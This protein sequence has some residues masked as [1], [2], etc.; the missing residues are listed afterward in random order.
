MSLPSPFSLDFLDVATP[1]AAAP[2]LTYVEFVS[3]ALILVGAPMLVFEISG[4]WRRGRLDWRR[5]TGMATS[6]FCL[7]PA[8]IAEACLAAPV[9]GIFFMVA[10]LAPSSIPTNATTALICLLLTDLVYYWEHR[11]EHEVN[12][13]WSLYHSVHHSADHFDQTVAVRISFVDYFITPLFYLPLVVAGF[14]PA[15]VF[16]CIGLTLAWQQWI[17][18][19][20]IGRLPLLDPWLNTPSNHRVHH[21]RNELYLDR[22]HGAILMIWDRLFGT[23]QAETEPVEYGLVTPLA[24]RSPLA[25]HFHLLRRLVET[26]AQRPSLREAVRLALSKP[27]DAGGDAR[28]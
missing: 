22:N 26:A 25:V 20:T 11:L 23:Y 7:A 16:A 21:G 6:A 9:A 10:T 15:L 24:A 27:G 19:E 5:A 4:L 18:T 14:H 12:A 3:L 1:A 28:R 17:H 13:L 2:L 8:Q